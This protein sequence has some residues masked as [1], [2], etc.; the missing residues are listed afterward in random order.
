MLS[1]FGPKRHLA[2]PIKQTNK[3]IN[4]QSKSEMK[5][6]KKRTYASNESQRIK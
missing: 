1:T 3:Q 4:N 6:K 2:H 5:M